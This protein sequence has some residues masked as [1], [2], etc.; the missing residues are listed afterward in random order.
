M[1]S[2]VLSGVVAGI[3]AG[4]AFGIM[5]TVMKAP[6]PEGTE[7]PMM[8]MVAMVV[9]SESPFIGWMYHLFN[10]ALIGGLFGLLLGSTSDRSMTRAAWIGTLYGVAWWVIGGLVLMPL[11]LGMPVFA[12]L[13]MPMMRSVAMGSL[14]GHVVFGVILAV[15][16]ARLS[17]QTGNGRLGRTGVATG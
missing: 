14:V 17:L 4:V 6:T 10:S 1:R 2:R 11:L 9:R 5:M 8:T 7:I 13:T 12:P 16:F 15:A 3:I